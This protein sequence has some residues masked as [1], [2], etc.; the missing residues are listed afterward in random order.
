MFA[1][2]QDYLQQVK[3]G[4]DRAFNEHL[5]ALL[6][7][8]AVR[9]AAVFKTSLAG[10]K[11]IRGG[12]L[13][14]LCEALGKERESAISR[15][16]AVELIQ[17]AS[18]I[19]DD[20]VDQD[21]TRRRNPAVWTLEGARKAVLLGDVIFASAIKM[22][23]DLSGEDGAVAAHAIAQ[24][25]RGAIHEPLEPLMLVREIES[26][27]WDH[28]LYE[29]II[30]LKTGILFGAACR[31]GAVAAQADDRSRESSHRYGLRIGEAYQI[32]DDMQ[33]IKHHIE[34][35]F[36]DPQK[37]VALAPACFYFVRE[38]RPYIITALEG[39]HLELAGDLLDY[40]QQAAKRMEAEIE[41]RLQWAASAI[42]DGFPKNAYSRLTRK[43]PWDI[44]RMFNTS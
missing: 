41:R 4:L 19:H 34:T 24:V 9:D 8:I 3:P 37:M 30:H 1:S 20:F 16:V 15:A 36:I 29:K 27:R 40:F 25:S 12:L 33:D 7:D 6:G 21:A 22:M 28:R 44:I 5:S 18:L 14:M 39:K 43:A 17:T 38:M 26:N 32:A 42:N 23:S 35:R 11:K 2:F 10:G 31:L 13:C